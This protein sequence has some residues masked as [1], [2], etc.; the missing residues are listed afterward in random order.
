MPPC[1]AF[2]KQRSCWGGPTTWLAAWYHNMSAASQQA[3]LSDGPPTWQTVTAHHYRPRPATLDCTPFHNCSYRG[4]SAASDPV[5]GLGD[6]RVP[7]SDG[8]FAAT[9]LA[10]PQVTFAAATEAW[11]RDFPRRDLLISEFNAVRPRLVRCRMCA[12]AHRI[13]PVMMQHSKW[14]YTC[15]RVP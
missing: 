2:Y 6:D 15:A 9:M 4:E 3:V 14:S 12:C 11:R 7:K 13:H 10:F 1:P 5:E 8:V